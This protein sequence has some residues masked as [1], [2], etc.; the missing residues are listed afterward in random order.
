[1]LLIDAVD[2]VDLPGRA[3][4]GRRS[5]RL[6]DVGFAGHFPGEAVYPGALLVETMGQLGL[7]LLHFTSSG[8]HEVPA[9]TTPPRVRATHIHYAAFLAPVL[10]GDDLTLYA[11]VVDDS[12]TTIAAG[13]AYKDGVLAACGISEVYVDE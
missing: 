10:P 3:V 13:Q 9:D 5:V 2:M 11:Q 4:R 1:M 7:T 8:G 6:S 12:F